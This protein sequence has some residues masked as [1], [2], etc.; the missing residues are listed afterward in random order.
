MPNKKSSFFGSL[1]YSSFFTIILFIFLVLSS[2]SLIKTFGRSQDIK[3]RIA[4]LETEI[5][6]L[7]GDKTDFLQTI[8]YLKTDF[9]KEKEAREK[10]GLQKPGEKVIV[11]LPPEEAPS[12]PEEKNIDKWWQFLFK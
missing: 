7:E 9:Y 12:Q 4:N 3:Q 11:V 1:L 2:I 8:E 5:N 10:F 6:K